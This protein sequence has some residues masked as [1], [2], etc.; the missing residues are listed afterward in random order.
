M[1][2]VL[3]AIGIFVAAFAGVLV[4]GRLMAPTP[5]QAAAEAQFKD[6]F[7]AEAAQRPTQEAPESPP[8]AVPS[9][10]TGFARLQAAYS[11]MDAMCTAE[12]RKAYGTAY[13]T[14]LAAVDKEQTAGAYEDRDWYSKRNWM[15]NQF[16]DTASRDVIVGADMPN[17]DFRRMVTYLNDAEAMPLTDGE[18]SFGGRYSDGEGKPLKSSR[19][20]P[21]ARE[22]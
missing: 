16:L 10:E 15:M 8:S 5:E 19:C 18:K 6:A 2:T 20:E 22:G 3:L 4:Y 7:L 1:K 12:S 9:L 21:L 14:F 13:V 11:W 17:A